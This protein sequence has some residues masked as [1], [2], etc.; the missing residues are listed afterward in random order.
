MSIQSKPDYKV[1]ASGAKP[2]EI[3]TFP[4][5]L[6]G[7]GVTIDR[8]GEIPP[9]EWFN[10]IG[11]RVDEWLMY[12]SQRGVSEW[13]VLLGY[14]KT[15]IVQWG[16]V[17]YV[18]SRETKGEK[19]DESQAAWST[20]SGFLKLGDYATKVELNN[21]LDAK[22]DKT[23][24]VQST[25]TSTTQAMSQMA[26]TDAINSSYPTGAPIPW[27]QPSPPA[28]YLVC[29]GQSFNKTTYPLLAKAYPSGTLPDLRSEFI[30]GADAGR[31]IDTGRTALSSQSDAIRNIVGTIHAH[32]TLSNGSVT[33][34]FSK[35]GDTAPGWG[36][37]TSDI[38][39]GNI[40]F[41][42]GKV[43][44]VANENRPRNIAF[45]YIVRAA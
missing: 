20:L 9:M 8:T 15:A 30:R 14:P 28:G 36:L 43:V 3:D 39:A 27:T 7:W 40:E 42:A 45:L 5:I 25:G 22:L 24:I 4:D 10:A 18:S 16:G 6:R 29:N 35:I 31:N 33:G 11:K 17:F 21:G 38:S 23:S 26:V 41:N 32:N 34:A 37:A 19:P 2:G 12:L 13:D 44:P 1:F